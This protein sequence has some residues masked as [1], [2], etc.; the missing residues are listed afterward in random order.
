MDKIEKAKRIE[1]IK[2][3]CGILFDSEM[4]LYCGGH[5][6]FIRGKLCDNCLIKLE[7]VEKND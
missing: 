3:G 4:G 7:E 2:E 6:R 5:N 1:K